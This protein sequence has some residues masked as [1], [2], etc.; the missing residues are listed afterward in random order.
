MNSLIR[1]AR[2]LPDVLY[3]YVAAELVD[4][5][6]D[7]MIVSGGG[8]PIDTVHLSAARVIL[9]FS[10]VQKPMFRA[11]VHKLACGLSLDVV[12]LRCCLTP[13]D[14]LPVSADVTLAGGGL[15]PFD[16]TDLSLYRHHDTGL[17][18][19]PGGFGAALRLGS[20][21][22][23]LCLVPPYETLLERAAGIYR[24]ACELAALLYPHEAN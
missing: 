11:K 23:E 6:S 21:G 8:M 3:T 13:A 20:D 19:V 17:W 22:V 5:P 24:T 4:D 1:P 7:A 10:C 12:L 9:S 16:M 14:I 15:V 18:L 2:T